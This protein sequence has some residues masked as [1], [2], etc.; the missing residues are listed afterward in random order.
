MSFPRE[1]A[2]VAAAALAADQIFKNVMLYPLRFICAEPRPA[3]VPFL[4]ECG[5]RD[6]A[7]QI[8]VTPFFDFVMVWNRGVSYGLFQAGGLTG[9][10]ILIGFSLVAVAA[11]SWWLRTADR[12]ILAWGLGLII[13]GA[14]GNVIDRAIYGAVADFF[15]FHAFGYDWYV[16]NV[17]DAAITVGVV[18]LLVDAF[19]RPE[20]KNSD[21]E[22]ATRK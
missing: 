22:P 8:V 1:G 16:F 18:A 6:L 9:T 7:P 3:N 2:I 21:R 19:A 12:R 15:R 14:L 5:L 17:A 13:G 4:P 20:A 11:L 10:L